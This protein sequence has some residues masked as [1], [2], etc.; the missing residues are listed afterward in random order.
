MPADYIRREDSGKFTHCISFNIR[1]RNGCLNQL[2]SNEKM[3]M[4]ALL[5]SG[6]VI[7]ILFLGCKKS[8]AGSTTAQDSS[9]TGKWVYTSFYIGMGG[10]SVNQ[11]ANP[12]NQLTTFHEDGSMHS[13]VSFLKDYLRFEIQDSARIRLFPSTRPAGYLL[14]GYFF[15]TSDH[16]L[17]IFPADPLCIEG[18]GYIFKRALF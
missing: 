1:K 16:S 14:M 18:C 17:T 6:L 10:P 15:N 12:P 4:R 13:T 3:N 9:F 8:G 11:P 5:L 2:V 7:L